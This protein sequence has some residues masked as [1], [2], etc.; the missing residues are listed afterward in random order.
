V[1]LSAY[2]SAS[3]KAEDAAGH[4]AQTSIVAP[5][6]ASCPRG[7]PFSLSRQFA[8]IQNR[9]NSEPMTDYV[10][11]VGGGYFFAPPGARGGADFVGSGL[12][13]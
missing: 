9:L 10:T 2:A 12:F 7:T 5:S 13:A 4:L 11:P 1:R 3:V 6:A 8:V